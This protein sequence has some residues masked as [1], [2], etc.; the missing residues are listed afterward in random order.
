MEG[1]LTSFMIPPIG[2]GFEKIENDQIQAA[3]FVFGAQT[4]RP[5]ASGFC[6]ERI[7]VPSISLNL[8]QLEQVEHHP[9][10]FKRK[11]REIRAQ[12]ETKP[13]STHAQE[14]LQ[15]DFELRAVEKKKDLLRRLFRLKIGSIVFEK[16]ARL[17][18]TSWTLSDKSE[19]NWRRIYR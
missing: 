13:R 14:V 19:Y 12:M 6:V 17:K 18:N 8:F 16:P 10:N 9:V 2:L 5:A 3:R 4:N 15:L 1:K 11:M 7:L